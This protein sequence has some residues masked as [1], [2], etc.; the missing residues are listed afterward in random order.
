MLVS[1][2]VPVY[3]AEKHLNKCLDSIAN[4]T[5]KHLEVIMV[6]DGSSDGS[7]KIC[8]EFSEKDNRFIVI[9]Q[10]NEGVSSARNKGLEIA[11]GDYIGFVDSDDWIDT[12]MFDRL[13]GLI[14]KH[15]ADI[16]ICGYAKR[17]E[18]GDILHKT[19]GEE[20]VIMSEFQTL[21][22]ITEPNGFG[23]YLCNKL[24]SKSVINGKFDESIHFCEDLL[25]CVQA[26]LKSNKVVYDPSPLYHYIE[27]GISESQ[28]SIKKVTALNAYEKIISLLEG[29]K[30]VDINKYKT[31]FMHINLS[32]LMHGMS[33]RKI[34]RETKRRLKEN[35]TQYKVKELRDKS[36]QI[37]CILARVNI[38]FAFRIWKF[39]K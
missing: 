17:S 32:L 7:A 18:A 28:Y 15:N 26:L 2:I 14:N 12:N 36:V 13:Y 20:T 29:Y 30:D 9:H 27:G 21:N 4:Q 5:Y 16:A 10:E 11:K 39:N 22:K 19:T 6:N 8:D 35:I 25:F 33:E 34:N 37:L 3:N 24:F 23:G 1:I 38:N 31:N